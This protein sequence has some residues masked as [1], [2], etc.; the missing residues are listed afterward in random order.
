MSRLGALARPALWPVVLGLLAGCAQ[1]PVSV[2]EEQFHRLSIAPPSG[3][4]PA[5]VLDGSLEVERFLADGLVT[6]RAIAYARAED[7][8][9]LHQYRYHFWSDTPTR[10]LQHATAD[11]LR[12]AGVAGSVVTP[13]LRVQAS[14]SLLCHIR[15]LEH[16]I[17]SPSR[18]FVELECALRR[19]GDGEILLL[20]SYREA[21][22]VESANIAQATGAMS[23]AFQAIL[24]AL[25][26]DVTRL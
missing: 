2:Q 21:R 16:L 24:A 8:D 10:M 5:R 3:A 26:E 22:T 23:A 15:R 11:Y 17:G 12:S 18:V 7:P 4:L 25:L 6:D 19:N 1:Q 14:Y 9:V 13:E 20:E